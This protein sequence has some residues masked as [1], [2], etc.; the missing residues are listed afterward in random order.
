MEVSNS[1]NLA[2]HIVN[3]L[4]AHLLRVHYGWAYR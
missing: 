3:I 4:S 2:H 1:D